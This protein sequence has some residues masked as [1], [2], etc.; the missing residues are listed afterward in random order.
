M[1]DQILDYTKESCF[2]DGQD[3]IELYNLL[4]K[5]LYSKLNPLKYSLIT[6]NTS[7]QFESKLNKFYYLNRP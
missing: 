4:V 5:D 6:I 7:R 1:T 3:L 2:N